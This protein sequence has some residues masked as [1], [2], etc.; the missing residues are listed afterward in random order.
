MTK[1]R[2]AILGGEP[3]VKPAMQWSWPPRLPELGDRLR[4][5]YCDSTRPLSIKGRDGIL[6]DCE[7]E[8]KRRFQRRHAILCSSGTMAL[9]SAYFASGLKPGDEVI[10]PTVTYHA[11][12]TPA[13]HLGAHIVLVDVEPD[14][15]NIDVESVAR[16]ITPRTRVVA[17]NA[18]W[19]HPVAQEALRTLCD[20][21]GL[22]WIEDVS[23]AHLSAYEGR[24]VGSWGDIACASL[25]GPKLVSGGEGGVLLTDLDR[26]HDQAVLLGHNLERSQRFVT[27]PAFAPIG[28]TGYGLKLRCPPLAALMIHYQLVN[29]ADK[30]VEERRDSLMRLSRELSV[31][32]GFKPPVIRS[33][34][35]S[36]GAW[37]GYKPHIDEVLLRIPRE[38]LVKALQAEGLDVDV[39]GA[40]MLHTLALFD[41]N[42]FQIGSFSKHDNTHARFPGADFYHQGLLSLPTPTGARDSHVLQG[43]IDGFHK[44]WSNLDALR[45]A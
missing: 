6:A 13:L 37:Y 8:L 31:L 29:H 33:T 26:V 2:L 38:K 21:H 9:Y 23:H 17:S 43:L 10:C 3:V 30:W 40:A 18:M 20:K 32:A 5:Y 12:A 22:C 25:Q 27:D 42:R 34:T 28:R 15:G 4:D 7:D 11:T 39:P 45:E 19:G 14:T 35:S 16:A 36:M 24:P 44:V 41:P 1:S